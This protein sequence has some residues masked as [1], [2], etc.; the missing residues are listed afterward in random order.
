MAVKVEVLTPTTSVS[1]VA[2][3]ST[4]ITVVRPAQSPISTNGSQAVVEVVKTISVI[5]NVIVSD[6]E[7][8]EPFEGMVW[9]EVPS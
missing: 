1:E 7:P 2:G 5:N 6:T 8:E 4:E 3:E 9:I